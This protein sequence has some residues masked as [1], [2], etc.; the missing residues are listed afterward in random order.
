MADRPERPERPRSVRIFAYL[1]IGIVLLG[2]LPV[3][4]SKLGYQFLPSVQWVNQTQLAA[5][6][7]GGMAAAAAP[8]AVLKGMK[9]QPRKHGVIMKFLIVGF[10]PVLGFMFVSQSVSM[11]IPLAAAMAAGVES[12]AEYTVSDAEPK[13]AGKCR[14]PVK[15]EN[16]PFAWSKICNFPAGFVQGLQPGS[17]II[18]E[19]SGTK[20]GLFV[21]RLSHQD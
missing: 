4:S 17:R 15:V 18:A 12:Q 1:V 9:M 5:T 14:D 8:F 21:T 19:G 2:A 20:L 7:L 11:G 3:I 13:K 10:S 6:I 16:M